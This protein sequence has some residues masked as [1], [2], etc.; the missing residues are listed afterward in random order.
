MSHCC[1]SSSPELTA[2]VEAAMSAG[3]GA[4]VLDAQAL[5]RLR[6][7]D[8]GGKA[9]LLDRVLATY[10]QTLGR[11]L[12][13]FRTARGTADLQTLRHVSHALKSSSASVGAL[14]LAS[15]CADVEARVRDGLLEGLDAHLDALDAEAD[16]I[17][18]G[19][20]PGASR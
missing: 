7:L 19:L 17:L 16:R 6:E 3:G 18:T 5:A 15:K 12:G 4:G 11:M 13:Q 10:T 14:A 2:P 8:P 1:N 9:G 20:G